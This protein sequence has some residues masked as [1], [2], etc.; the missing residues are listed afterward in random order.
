MITVACVWVAG[1]VHYPIE[2]VLRLR[3]MV[4]RH[5]TLPHH[6]VCLTDR[7]HLLHGIPDID[8]IK[9][10]MPVGRF[11]WWSKIE[12]FNPA[13]PLGTK[14]LY[15]DLDSIV[16][17]SLNRVASLPH[18]YE[19]WLVPD[20]GSFKGKGH[21]RV[22]KR[23]NSSV[24]VFNRSI[25][26]ASIFRDWSPDVCNTLW[27]DQDWIAQ[28]LPYEHTMP[29]EWFPRLSELN[30]TDPRQPGHDAIVVLCKKP[31]NEEAAEFIPWV[32]EAW[33]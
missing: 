31:K 21:L 23:Y 3:S 8:W 9:V 1:N 29:A 25:K 20:G 22:V 19:M 14:V 27:G 30:L 11:G 13:H 33:A 32:R 18:D 2:Y 5:L 28:C 24:M 15:L 7:P 17:R 12:L 16:V 4:K 10:P 26:T 6:F